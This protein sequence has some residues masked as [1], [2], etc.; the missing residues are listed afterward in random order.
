MQRSFQNRTV[1]QIFPARRLAPALFASLVL[2]PTLASAWG[3]TGHRVVG[4]VAEHHL[5]EIAR[6]EIRA[7]LGPETL[8]EAGTYPDEIRSDPAMRHTSP[9][10]WVTI[11]D[12]VPYAA[13]EKNPEGD[14]IESIARFTATVRGAEAPLEDRRFALRFLAHQIGDLH[15]PLHVGTGEDRG[16][17]QVEVFW[18]GEKSNLHRIWDSD[19]IDAAKLSFSELAERID[20]A[21]AA[22]IR[23]WQ[24][25]DWLAW[26]EES[27]G[28]RELVYDIGDGQLGYVYAYHAMP[29]VERRLLQAGIRLAGLLNAIFDTPT[30]P[31]PQPAPPAGHAAEHDEP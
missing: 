20:R 15:Q 23:A 18:H 25:T 27:K 13:T 9:W 7:L 14:L 30:T 2:I 5:S 16:G 11:P 21:D 1:A 31:L 6:Q 28:L 19:M 12:G 26:A 8:A 22:Q 24:S 29:V 17:N 3:S 4:Q 10:H